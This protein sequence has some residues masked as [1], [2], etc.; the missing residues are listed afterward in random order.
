MKTKRVSAEALRSRRFLAP[1]ALRKIGGY[2]FAVAFILVGW[3]ATSVAL[4]SPALP[5]PGAT[6]A[7]LAANVHALVPDFVVSAYR[8]VASVAIGTVLAVILVGRTIAVFNHFTKEK[9]T[10]LAG[11]E[12]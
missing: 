10:A 7:V 1:S 11:I 3:W 2:L 4:H 8:V 5:T 6:F 12:E 9:L